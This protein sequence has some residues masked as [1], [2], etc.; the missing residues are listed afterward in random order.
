MQD[1]LEKIEA[2]AAARLTLEPGRLATEE[3]PRYKA[4]LKV[5]THRLKR[6]H[7]AVGGGVEICRARAAILDVIIRRL[8]ETAKAS[9]SVQAQNEFP[10]LALAAIGGFG[11]AELNPHSDIDFMFLH[12]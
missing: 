2:N 7:R 5:D 10:E 1:L 4:F 11:R 8:W 6:L 12:N 3:L 9:L